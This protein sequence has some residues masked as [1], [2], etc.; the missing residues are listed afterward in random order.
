MKKFIINILSAS[1]MH[2]KYSELFID[3]LE[4]LTEYKMRVKEI[5]KDSELAVVKINESVVVEFKL[6]ETGYVTAIDCYN[7]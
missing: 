7:A 2:C 4:Q 5:G 1:F 6:S 3:K